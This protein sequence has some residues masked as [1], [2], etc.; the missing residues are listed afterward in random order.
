MAFNQ[1]IFGGFPYLLIISILIVASI[2]HETGMSDLASMIYL[3][4]A[5]YLII[6]FRKFYTQ[7]DKFLSN[8]RKYNC[9]VL[10][11]VLL[12]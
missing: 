4:F 11:S 10:F 9:I 1:L 5:F 6:N 8:L 7:G 2:F 3:F 12:F